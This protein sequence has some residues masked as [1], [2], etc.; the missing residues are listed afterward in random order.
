MPITKRKVSFTYDLSDQLEGVSS[1]KASQIKKAVGQLLIA[2][3]DTFTERQESPVKSQRAFKELTPEYK[4]IKKK[5]GKG[6]KANLK[7]DFDML[8]SWKIN[9]KPDG[10]ELKI[11]DSLE[12]KKA[13]RHNVDGYKGKKQR[14]FLPDDNKGQDFKTAIKKKVDNL[15]EGM[16]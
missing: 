5:K 4:A 15:I 3:I 6:T 14:R 2:E 16:L 12:K 8:D 11:T 1:R 7:L 9:N 13:F 10:V